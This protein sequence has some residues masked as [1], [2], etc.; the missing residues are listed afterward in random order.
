MGSVIGYGFL[1]YAIIVT[2]RWAGWHRRLVLAAAALLTL[3]IG[4]SR[5]YI[6]VHYPSD[7]VGGWAAGVAWLA[8]CITG[9]QVVSARS[10][11]R[12]PPTP[13][14]EAP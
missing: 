3:L 10:A 12:H 11:L 8:V 2:T 14:Q 9:Y 7:V 1:A 6:G 4:L 5:V 13:A